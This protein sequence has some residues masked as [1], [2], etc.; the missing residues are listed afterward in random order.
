MSDSSY[1][2]LLHQKFIKSIVSLYTLTH[3]GKI[4]H[5]SFHHFWNHFKNFTLF[6]PSLGG[7]SMLKKITTFTIVQNS[8]QYQGSF[9]VIYMFNCFCIKWW[10]IFWSSNT[11]QKTKVKTIWL[12]SS[13]P[14][15]QCN[16]SATVTAT[17][18]T[19]IAMYCY[20]LVKS[21]VCEIMEKNYV[22]LS[23]ARTKCSTLKYSFRYQ[24][25]S[26]QNEVP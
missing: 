16:Q 26:Q 15:H 2:G 25:K 3:S 13:I 8:A 7:C 12:P 19:L 14:E 6:W 21:S 23:C 9:Q 10:N 17:A 5:V 20:I 24:K 18:S 4:S 11:F 1:C 22:L